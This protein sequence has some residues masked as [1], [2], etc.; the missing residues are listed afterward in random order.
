MQPHTEGASCLDL[1]SGS[2]A[3]SFEALSRG[4]ARAALVEQDRQLVSVLAQQ[5]R[6]LGAEDLLDIHCADALSWL[7]NP[8]MGA[9]DIVFLDPP[10]GRQLVEKTCE[11]LL[12]NGYLGQNGR[13]YIESEP[14]LIIKNAGLRQIRQ[15]RAG[16]VQY[17]LLKYNAN[18]GELKNENCSIIPGN[19]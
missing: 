4:A 5:A 1:F 14:G 15:R 8:A 10:F 16:Q 9:Y 11:L 6:R 17:Q 3:L 7:A 19:I 2:G 12:K 18:P 13:V